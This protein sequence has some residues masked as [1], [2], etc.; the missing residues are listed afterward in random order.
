MMQNIHQTFQDLGLA[1]PKPAK[2]AASYLP[3]VMHQ[4]QLIVSGQL[5][6]EEG[7]LPYTGPA[8]TVVLEKAQAAAQQSVLNLLAQVEDA[9]GGDWSRL[10]RVLRLG[11][12]VQAPS[13]YQDAH[14]VANGASDVMVKLFGE[15]GKHARAAICASSLPMNAMVEVEGAFSLKF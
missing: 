4:G 5:P 11:I 6:M 2:P 14:L 1:L 7:S 3:Y 13:G 10:K 15:Q 8:D 9:L 12:F